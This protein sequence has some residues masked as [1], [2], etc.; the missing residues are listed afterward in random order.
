MD[1]SYMSFFVDL[2]FTLLNMD[3][4]KITIFVNKTK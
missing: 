1:T 4:L 2:R 3:L